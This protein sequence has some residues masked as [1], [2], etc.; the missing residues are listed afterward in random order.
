MENQEP[1]RLV[2]FVGA[3]VG[4]L[5]TREVHQIFRIHAGRRAPIGATLPESQPQRNPPGAPQFSPHRG[6]F[7]RRPAETRPFHQ[8]KCGRSQLSFSTA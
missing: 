3:A 2:R 5:L 1:S 4:L 8:A 6:E 7:G